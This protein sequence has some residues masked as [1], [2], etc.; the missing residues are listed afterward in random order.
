MVDTMIT[1]IGQSV[2]AVTPIAVARYLSA[3]VNGGNVYQAH[4]VDRVIDEEGNT[5]YE[6]EPTLVAQTGVTQEVTDAVKHGMQQA[7]QYGS[8]SSRFRGYKYRT[9]I[10]GKT[11]TAQVSDIDVEDELLVHVLCSPFIDDPEIVVVIYIPNGYSSSYCVEPAKQ[12]VQYYLDRQ[13]TR[14]GFGACGGRIADAVKECSES[15]KRR[16]RIDA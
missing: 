13:Q 3:L 9:Q 10:G 7:I 5:V 15:G 12:I 11:G 1:G 2:T 8:V 6:K 4:V 16:R 14:G